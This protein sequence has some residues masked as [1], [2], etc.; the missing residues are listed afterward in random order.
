[1]QLHSYFNSSTSFRVR[2]AL[3]LKG[4]TYE[5]I[6][7]NLKTHANRHKDF[8]ALNPLGGVPILDDGE[9]LLTQSLA[10][11]DYLDQ[12]FPEPPLLPIEPIRRAHVLE[13]SN[14][15]ACDIH[16]VNNM[17]V[18]KYLKEVL[19]ADQEQTSA[20]YRH[21]VAQGMTAIEG[22]LQQHGSSPFCFGDQPTLADCCLAPQVF[23]ALRMGCELDAFERVGAVYWHC[24]AHPAFQR[25]APA[26]QPDYVDVA[27]AG[28]SAESR[29]S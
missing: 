23:N 26:S 22:L 14:V 11:V 29:P 9:H 24:M 6:P 2:I 7:V 3:A 13:V 1:M 16:P 12:R 18:L 17:R 21:W 15:I 19:G 5:C 8:L 20:W 4:V 28:A 25:S 10:I 27:P